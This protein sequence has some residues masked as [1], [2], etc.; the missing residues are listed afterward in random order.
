[1]KNRLP[2]GSSKSLKGCYARVWLSP[3]FVAWAQRNSLKA[4]GIAPAVLH[5]YAL[6]HSGTQAITI[7]SSRPDAHKRVFDAKGGK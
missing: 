6:R 2:S 5:T 7:H 4:A 1:M 3:E